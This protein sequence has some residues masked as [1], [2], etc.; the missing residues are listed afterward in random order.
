MYGGVDLKRILFAVIA[1]AL[2]LGGSLG[3]LSPT[4]TVHADSGTITTTNTTVTYT[5]GPFF[6]SNPTDTVNS[7]GNPTCGTATPCDDYT[8]NVNVPAGTDA[9]SQIKVAIQ[10]PVAAAE[11]DLFVVNSAGQYI[12]ANESGADP[13]V[14]YIPA[15][16]G[17]Y[18]VRVDPFNPAGQTYTATIDLEA[19]PNSASGGAPAY[20]GTPPR[21]QNYPIPQSQGGNAGEPSIGYN[22]STG[23]VMYQAGLQTFKVGFDASTSPAKATW[24]D[25]SSFST[26]K[27][28][29]DAILFTDRLTGR[30]FSSQLTGQDSLSAFSDNDGG[31]W[32][33]SQGGGIPSGVDHQTIGG[34]PY[35]KG[36][37]VTPPNAGTVTGYKNAVYYCSQDIAASFCA[38]SDDGGLTF[39][40]GVPTW[41][42]TQCGGLHGH[43]KV[44]PNDGT[45]Y[46]PN[47]NCGGKQGVAVSTDDGTTWSIRTIPDSTAAVGS[48][49]SVGIASDGTL[50]EGYQAANGNA[51]IAVSHDRGLTWSKS[52]DVGLQQ[53]VQ[54]VVFPEVV[55]GD[56]NRAAFAYIGTTTG[57]N[58]QSQTFPGTW[59]MYV[60]TTY[61]GGQTWT[62]VNDTPTD[63]VQRGSICTNGTTCGTDRNLLD[64]MDINM[65]SQG[66]V[67]VG[68]PD[69]CVNA[70][71]TATTDATHPTQ[72]SLNSGT[73]YATIA[74]QSG[75]L[76]LLS[77][78]DTPQPSAPARPALSATETSTSGAVTLSWQA[79]DNGGSPITAYSLYKGK[80]PTTLSYLTSVGTHQSYVDKKVK[81]GTTY[82]YDLVATNA[83]GNS[84]A[85]PVVSPVLINTKPQCSLPGQLVLTDPAGDQV[86]APNNADL[87]ILSANIAELVG[88]NNFV[89]TLNVADLSNPGSNHQWR[90]FWDDPSVTGQ[91][92]YAGMDTSLTGAVSFNYGTIAANAGVP[93][94]TLPASAGSGY[95]ADGTI[96]IVVPKSGVGN[97]AAGS[98]L[99]NVQARTFLGQADGTVY[100]TAAAA[101]VTGYSTYN[102]VGNSYCG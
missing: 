28:S 16:A 58:Y 18:T 52:L 91:R 90:I 61:D 23:N 84:P 59:Q 95:A 21:F 42:L 93:L 3:L 49:P 25:V 74:R 75:G 41:D 96:T 67:L 92:Y 2:S 22:P 81:A 71:V 29:L 102:V 88:N 1:V 64:F 55:A 7:D 11:F 17:T 30:T 14:V 98:T 12:A 39:G 19:K 76:S 73:A 45:V 86:G 87:D 33:P 26:S 89:F 85:S 4:V 10:W 82:Y 36:G 56:P 72:D 15:I 5:H 40:A 101:D 68:Y 20:T 27:A 65:D 80:S 51:Y 9:T 50:Y 57:G 46:V 99:T 35:S 44:A 34:G 54:N 63:S 70:C 100:L 6:V 62:T 37:T 24:T 43:V 38:R 8:L 77:A 66:R 60:S 31:A 13:T 83:V 97:P 32:T 53:N 48:D 78:Y 94:T 69:G 79:P 47:K